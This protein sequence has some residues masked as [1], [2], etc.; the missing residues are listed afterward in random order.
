MKKTRNPQIRNNNVLKIKLTS[1]ETVVSAI[2][3]LLMFNKKSIL[4][5]GIPIFLINLVI[6]PPFVKS[7]YN[8]KEY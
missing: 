3:A 1:A 5:S 2:P 7:S 4:I 8:F 6:R